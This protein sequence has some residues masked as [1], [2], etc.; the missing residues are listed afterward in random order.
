MR[1]A[2]TSLLPTSSVAAAARGWAASRS[3]IPAQQAADTCMATLRSTV[4]RCRRAGPSLLAATSVAA[5]ARRWGAIRSWRSTQLA[6]DLAE[7]HQALCHKFMS[8]RLMCWQK[9]EQ[10]LSH[11]GGQPAAPGLQQ[12]WLLKPATSTDLSLT[13]LDAPGHGNTSS[14]GVQPCAGRLMPLLAILQAG[15]DRQR[16]TRFEHNSVRWSG[17]FATRAGRQR[18]RQVHSMA[19]NQRIFNSCS[20]G[21][22]CQ[23]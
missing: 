6:A 1:E 12:R 11:I 8:S 15:G 16:N 17:H 14:R 18:L 5:A 2:S 7:L 19:L 3:L 9:S 10:P 21:C 23:H 22:W 4:C 13:D 20:P